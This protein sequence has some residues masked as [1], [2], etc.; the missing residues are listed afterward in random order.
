MD[1]LGRCTVDGGSINILDLL[2]NRGIKPRRAAGTHGGEY[3]SACPA[4]GGN[5]RFHVW[6][7]QNKDGTYWCRQC[8]KAGDAIQFLMDFEGMSFPEACRK[9]GRSL[10]EVEKY[11]LPQIPARE[12]HNAP[13][14]RPGPAVDQSALWL[15]KAGAFVS[16]AHKNLLEDGKQLAW[17]RKRGIKKETASR[18]H[19]GCNPG[20]DGKDIWR[21]RSS[22]GLPSELKDNGKEKRLWIPK[23]LVIP[24]LDGDQARRIRIRRPE[25]EPRYYVLPGSDMSAQL[26][27]TESRA[28]VVVESD[29]DA[30]LLDQEAGDCGAGFLALGSASAKSVLSP[31]TYRVLRQAPVILI[32]LDFD[33]AGAKAAA[34]WKE[35]FP[36]AERHPVPQGKDPGEA[37][38]A[39]IDLKE[40]V[41]AGFPAGWRIGQSLLGCKIGKRGDGVSTLEGADQDA[42]GASIPAPALELAELLR[43]HPVSIAIYD[44]NNR[45]IIRVRK[46]QSWT[47]ANWET[48]KRL[49]ELIFLTDGVM[50]FLSQSPEK[51]I[52]GENIGEILDIKKM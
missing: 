30:I 24:A 33:A 1:L 10:P 8:E 45:K 37:F 6:P 32:A 17:L 43:K 9:L 42:A 28:F 47:Q 15:E 46:T 48:S 39:G 19:L 31:E 29:L 40:W 36:Q 38:Q 14:E 49:S 52:T 7:E 35:N 50:E 41:K 21:P 51:I 22:W 12:I 26:L 44:E 34:W 25:G 16:W 27:R 13:P 11:R 18:F 4:C 5:D 2:N 3:H 20:Q 23:G